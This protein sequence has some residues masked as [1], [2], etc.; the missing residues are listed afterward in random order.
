M[1][2]VPRV[3]AAAKGRSDGEDGHRCPGGTAFPSLE[4]VARPGAETACPCRRA[5]LAGRLFHRGWATLDHPGM[6]DRRLRPGLCHGDVRERFD[7][8]GSAVCP[9]LHPAFACPPRDLKWISLHCAHV[10]PVE[11]DISGHLHAY[12]P[13]AR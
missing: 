5:R 1:S 6:A 13:A 12:W 2:F 9:V 4:L 7:H 11:A 3:P 8:R 10:N